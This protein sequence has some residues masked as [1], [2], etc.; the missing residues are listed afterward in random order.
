MNLDIQQLHC[1][2]SI[3]PPCWYSYVA[4]VTLRALVLVLKRALLILVRV[5]YIG[6][7]VIS[8]NMSLSRWLF[9]LVWRVM[10]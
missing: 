9:R 8:P 3:L 7:H 5:I 10:T 6:R 1:T 2:V 4:I